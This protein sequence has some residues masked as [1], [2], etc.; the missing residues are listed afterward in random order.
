MELN[1]LQHLSDAIKDL[2][3]AADNVLLAALAAPDTPTTIQLD[4]IR[5]ELIR[6]RK[7][8]KAIQQAN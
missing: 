8:I 6:F 1:F 7:T 2:E 5:E 3:S 4:D